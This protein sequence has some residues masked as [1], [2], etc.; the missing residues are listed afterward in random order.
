MSLHC[1]GMTSHGRVTH[2]NA[3]RSS[4]FH[5]AARWRSLAARAQQPDRMRRIGLLMVADD[6]EG[7]ARVRSLKQGLQEL[8][9]IEGRNIQLET[10]FAGVDPGRMRA[11]AAELV[12]LAPDVIVG[13]TTPIV[14]ALRQA[15]SS[16]PIIMA[17]VTIPSSKAWFRAWHIR[18]GTSLAS[19]SSISKWS[20]SG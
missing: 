15:T 20:G 4:Q 13:N 3:H 18:A 2:G 8:G 10:R 17:A 1:M 7:Q 14:R 5:H 11:D 16:I 19:C 6:R 9:W 12:A